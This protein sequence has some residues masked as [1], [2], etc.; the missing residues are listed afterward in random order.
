MN[1]K[2]HNKTV[3]FYAYLFSLRTDCLGS[4]SDNIVIKSDVTVGD[5]PLWRHWPLLFFYA[6]V[7]VGY[8]NYD[9]HRFTLPKLQYL[10]LHQSTYL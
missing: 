4:H 6:A 5:V 2:R 8:K 1:E 7:C 9:E 3:Y 10:I